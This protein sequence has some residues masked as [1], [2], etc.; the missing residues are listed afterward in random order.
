MHWKN[1]LQ[2]K[3]FDERNDTI[4]GPRWAYALFSVAALAMLLGMGLG[5][6]SLVTGT[7]PMR[8]I[9]IAIGAFAVFSGASYHLGMRGRA[10]NGILFC[11]LSIAV[12]VLII[13]A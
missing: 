6:Y 11:V 4:G 13:R 5:M 12:F 9:G 8:A 1:L 10:K 2:L 7:D 3:F